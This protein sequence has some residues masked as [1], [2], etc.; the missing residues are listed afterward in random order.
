MTRSL[1]RIAAS[2]AAGVPVALGPCAA[3]AQQDG[4]ARSSTTAR[5][6][7]EERLADP[8]VLAA[9]LDKPGRPPAFPLLARIV[10]H[11]RD[12][13]RPSGSTASGAPAGS[14]MLAALERRLSVYRDRK[15]PVWLAFDAGADPAASSDDWARL[16]RALALSLSGRARVFEVIVPAPTTLNVETTVFDVKRAAVELRAA[17]PEITVALGVGRQW[18]QADLQRVYTPDLA[19]YVDAVVVSAPPVNTPAREDVKSSPSGVTVEDA[20]AWLDQVDRTAQVYECERI[21]SGPADAAARTFVTGELWRLGS[22]S[23][24]ASYAGRPE[25]GR[26]ALTQAASISDLLGGELTRLDPQAAGLSVTRASGEPVRALLLYDLSSF[27]TYL[28][29]ASAERA[30]TDSAR[31]SIRIA[32]DAKPRVRD[33]LATAGREPRAPGA[34]TDFARDRDRQRSTFSAPLALRPLIIDFNDALGEVVAERNDVT[35]R[36]LPSVGEIIARHQQVQ[37]AQ[38][39]ALEHYTASARMS[40]HFRPTVAD[41]G[42]DVVTENR[43]YVDRGGI[44]WEELSFSVNGSKWKEDRP[45]FP[46]LQPEKVLS[47]PLTL[48]LSDDYAYRLEGLASVDGDE[49]YVIRFDPVNARRSLYRG[50]VWIDRAMFVQRKL[51][52]VQ[53]KLSAPVVSNEETH[54]FRSVAKVANRDIVL[55]VRMVSRQIVLVAGRN[56]LVEK[57]TTFE[58]HRVNGDEFREARQTARTSNRIM[59]RDTERGV[60][61]YVKDGTQR[62]V[63]ERSTTS[64]KAIAMG[65]TLDPSFDFPLPIFGI[66]YLDF[67]FGGPDRQLALLFGG[68]LALGNVQRPRMLGTP[69][70]ASVDFFAIAVP[71]SD[72]V[73]DEAGEREADRLLTW[74]AST[75]VNVG[76]QFTSFQKLA[77]QYQF[78]F[79]GY[80]RDRTTAEDYEVPSS[81]TTHGIGLAYEYRRAGYSVVANGT[82]YGRARWEPWGSPDALETSARTYEKYS[83]NV[84]KDWY[85]GLFQKVHVNGAYF[86][87]RRLDRFSQYQFGLFDDTR[88]HGVPASGVRMSELAMV[89]GSYSF[90]LFE[91]YRFDLFLEQ[92][93]GI[94]R[95]RQT[96]WERITGLGV[97]FNVKAPWNTI[98]RVDAGKSFLPPRYRPTGST[99]VQVLLLKPLK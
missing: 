2:I 11:R 93:M 61:Y 52:A 49:C 6:A 36:A 43:F 53:T 78:R 31:V 17:N 57:E 86:G 42:Y 16:F 9:A 47:V 89:R 90:N 74:P 59:Y 25:V 19:S 99:V 1:R 70:D 37:A 30:P 83:L 60:R 87:G 26:A 72:R 18:T 58:G 71:A 28:V 46:L 84:S 45:P 56:L 39:S 15:I 66:N 98:L 91:Q 94:D 51:Q 13:E 33:V 8:P 40:Q 7:F 38:D 29:Y 63:S 10:V 14:F 24:L 32:T 67:D 68:V 81:T 79:D 76:Y 73:Y 41:P 4:P 80:V 35:G 97:A 34:V 77:A 64:A 96:D 12:L 3:L 27:G 55:P 69:L 48:R 5:I 50:T 82:W 92:A 44:E 20:R 65:V 23:V 54:Y 95:E 85:L 22:A 62:V 88:I 75:G 21:L